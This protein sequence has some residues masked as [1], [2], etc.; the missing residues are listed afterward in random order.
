M[1][2]YQ[3]CLDV[4]IFINQMFYEGSNLYRTPVKR[5]LIQVLRIK[6][7]AEESYL[8]AA[9]QGWKL[10]CRSHCQELS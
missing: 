2:F 9:D 5:M 6:K 7:A 4:I 8:W 10:L 3:F 1:K